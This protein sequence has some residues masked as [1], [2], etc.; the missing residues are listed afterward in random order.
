MKTKTRKTF[1][2]KK[3]WVA[4]YEINPNDTKHPFYDSDWACWWGDDAKREAENMAAE[5][6]KLTELCAENGWDLV[7]HVWQ[8]QGYPVAN[9]SADENTDEFQAALDVWTPWDVGGIKRLVLKYKA[10]R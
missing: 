3:V 10:P 6:S 7:V 5:Y 8:C 9:S 2:R 1:A 4:S